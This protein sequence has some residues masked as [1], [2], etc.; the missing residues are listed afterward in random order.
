MIFD[1][2]NKLMGL[3]SCSFFLPISEFTQGWETVEARLYVENKLAVRF[4]RA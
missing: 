4:N 2:D 1:A 3:P